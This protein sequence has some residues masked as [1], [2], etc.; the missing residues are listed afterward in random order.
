VIGVL[1]PNA[2]I[3]SQGYRKLL[4]N[5]IGVS[6]F[7]RKLRAA[8]EEETFEFGHIDK[9]VGSGKRRVP[10]IHSGIDL[11]VQFSE[12]DDRVIPMRWETL[13]YGHGCVDLSSRN[14][15]VRVAA[16]VRH[17]GDVTDPTIFRFPSHFARMQKRDIAVVYPEGSTFFVLVE[18][19]ELYEN[20]ILFRWACRNSP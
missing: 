12:T 16:G 4:E 2:T 14:G 9:L 18:L 20:D 19:L 3:Y 6:F 8:V 1:D 7:N 5:N 17:F 10:V 11:T 15:A 13:Q